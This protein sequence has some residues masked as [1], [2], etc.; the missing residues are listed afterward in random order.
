M[1]CGID[2]PRG[3]MILVFFFVPEFARAIGVGL[4]TATDVLLIGVVLLASCFG[5]LGF[6]RTVET[7]LGRRVGIVAF[8]LLTIV[9]LVAGDV[10][11][12][13]AAIAC[14]SW[15][16]Y[17]V[18]CNKITT[19]MLVM[20]AVTGILVQTATLF[21]AHAGTGFCYLR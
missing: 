10:Y 17:F 21:R 16:P 4:V 7:K 19:G 6:L 20:F 2:R 3:P 12:M 11:I 9:E 1:A 5:L 18:S 15:L 8:L 13:N 14:V